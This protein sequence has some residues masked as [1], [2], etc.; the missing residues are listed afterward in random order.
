MLA[1]R[2]AASVCIRT[3]VGRD[4]TAVFFIYPAVARRDAMLTGLP[5]SLRVGRDATRGLAIKAVG[6][7]GI[8]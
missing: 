1:G 7:A 8:K 4:A 5:Y 6:T 3:A 2:D